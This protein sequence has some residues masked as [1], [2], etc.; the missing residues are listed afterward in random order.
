MVNFCSQA[1]EAS[2]RQKTFNTKKNVAI[3][4]YDPV[5]YFK[6]G[7][8]E[9]NS[10]M[11]FSHEG[12]IYYFSNVENFNLFK[13]N[14]KKYEPQ[15]GGWCAYAMGEKGE[16]VKVDPET[17]KIVNGKLYLYYNFWGNNTLESWNEN[18][19]IL[20]KNAE[21]NWLKIIDQF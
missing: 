16:K 2:L 6:E 5:S 3:E 8:E 12:I 4:G 1:Q 9:G 7:P 15:Y 11:Q 18:E 19:E 17:Y 14:P 20:L 21:G 10:S 13:A